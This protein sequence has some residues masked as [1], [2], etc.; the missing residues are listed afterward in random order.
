M[1]R[2]YPDLRIV[3]GTPNQRCSACLWLRRSTTQREGNR[4]THQL[5]TYSKFI[6]TL[7]NPTTMYALAS[8][9][10][11]SRLL[12]QKSILPRAVAAA[13]VPNGAK[14]GRPKSFTIGD[15]LSA[16]VR[17]RLFISHDADAGAAEGVSWDE[18]VCFTFT[19]QC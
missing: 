3:M 10:S 9:R 16:K 15:K 4:S 2:K 5:L 12:L 6:G 11:S 13:A 8:A 17:L 1:H 18:R 19:R 7:A 14:A